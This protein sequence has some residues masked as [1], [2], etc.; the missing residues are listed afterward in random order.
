M[1]LL[2]ARFLSGLTGVNAFRYA[3]EVRAFVGDAFNVDLQIIDLDQMRADEG[4]SPPG[5]RYVPAAGATLQ[6][7]FQSIKAAQSFTRSGSQPYVGDAA[8]WRVPVFASDPLR[9]TVDIVFTLTE[10]GVS[11]RF[12]ATAAIL[13]D[14]DSGVC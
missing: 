3:T 2:G 4:H 11:R 7:A 14:D 9:G 8:I 12:R 10:G 6:A 1:A 13:L 5:L